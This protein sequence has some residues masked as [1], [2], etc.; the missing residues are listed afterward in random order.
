MQLLTKV[1]HKMA[2]A[3]LFLLDMRMLCYQGPLRESLF[4]AWCL[5]PCKFQLAIWT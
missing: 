3:F 1:A 2:V 4:G 5:I